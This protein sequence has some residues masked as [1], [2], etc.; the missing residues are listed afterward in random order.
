MGA[1]PVDGEHC[2]RTSNAPSTSTSNAPSTEH[3]EQARAEMARAER[4]VCAHWGVQSARGGEGVNAP[5][6]PAVPHALQEPSPADG[7]G[8]GSASRAPICASSN[9]AATDLLG[10]AGELVGSLQDGATPRSRA[11]LPGEA[12]GEEVHPA[13]YIYIYIYI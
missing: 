1:D 9:H 8:E 3:A 5:P 6:S 13:T 10:S 4:A 7:R 11:T 2:T 12:N